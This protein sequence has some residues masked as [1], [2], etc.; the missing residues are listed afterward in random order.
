MGKKVTQLSLDRELEVKSM[1]L[2]ST[3]VSLLYLPF[4]FFFLSPYFY[5]ICYLLMK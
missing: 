2:P 4:F 5:M 3:T 1:I